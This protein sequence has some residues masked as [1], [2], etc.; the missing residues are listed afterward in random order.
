M[1]STIILISIFI[2]YGASVAFFVWRYAKSSIYSNLA[3]ER[4]KAKNEL[5]EY[6]EK[7]SKVSYKDKLDMFDDDINGVPL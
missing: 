1:T 2:G 4:I 5:K 6:E 7:L 3:K